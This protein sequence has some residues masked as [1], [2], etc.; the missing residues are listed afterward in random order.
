[1]TVKVM[2]ETGGEPKKL[3][4]MSENFCEFLNGK[5]SGMMMTTV[6]PLLRETA[7]L[8]TKCPIAPGFYYLNDTQYEEITRKLMPILLPAGNYIT[9]IKSTLKNEIISTITSKMLVKQ[10]S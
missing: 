2:W 9:E 6:V 5:A 8:P 1:M 7:H 4:E 3:I 10:N